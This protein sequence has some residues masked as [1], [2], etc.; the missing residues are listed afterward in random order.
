M[1]EVTKKI[2]VSLR[3]ALHWLESGSPVYWAV[4]VTL[5]F[6][7]ILFPLY[8]PLGFIHYNPLVNW[9]DL[10]SNFWFAVAFI[11]LT[12]SPLG[13]LFFL[14]GLYAIGGIKFLWLG[15]NLVGG[16][17][18]D[19]SELLQVTPT[20]YI[21]LAVV[22]I[23]VMVSFLFFIEQKGLRAKRSYGLFMVC[24]SLLVVA[25]VFPIQ[26]FS[27]ITGK[28]IKNFSR[29]ADFLWGG[30]LYAVGYDLIEKRRTQVQLASY[31]G[32]LKSRVDF[33]DIKSK[34]NI[35]IIL[36]ESY[37]SPYRLGLETAKLNEVPYRALGRV[38]YALAPVFGGNSAGSEYEILCGNVEHYSFGGLTFNAFGR[39]DGSP[40]L[41]N[42]LKPADY[43]SFATIG[44]KKLFFNADRAYYS[45]GF[46]QTFS[47]EDHP[48]Q[49]LDGF[50]ISDR[51]MFATN[52]VNLV[53]RMR[54]TGKPVLNY[55]ATIAGHG[56]YYLN[57][58]LRPIKI[59]HGV[60]G[61]QQY[62]NRIWYT[63]QEL[64]EHLGQLKEIDPDS[65]VF[66]V[67][68][69][70][71]GEAVAAMSSKVSR[72]DILDKRLQDYVLLDNFKQVDAGH[73]AYN[74]VPAVI[75]NIL[76]GSGAVALAKDR[77]IATNMGYFDRE[78][79]A[80]I[81]CDGGG[82]PGSLCSV[83]ESDK[84]YHRELGLNIIKASLAH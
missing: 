74:E 48:K 10:L 42:L 47:Y 5:A 51:E 66:I 65:I 50:R 11:A 75:R 30:Q 7:G 6:A 17:F 56:P 31:S 52:R 46:S 22:A 19:L 13:A 39:L 9:T 57:D 45:M 32:I 81:K 4:L 8:F 3:R 2:D 24:V 53:Q 49:D 73:I 28:N 54:E 80:P 21:F 59:G 68:D 40:C 70:L 29:G 64:N 76:A 14:V 82:L 78:S 35:H 69:H 34:K 26:A 20:L 25:C 37:T 77:P 60:A 23:F 62:L 15:R 18:Y 36:L 38:T 43:T 12:G 71:V 61:V 79:L 84:A 16:D 63:S 33:H 1:N 41:P 55:L 58:A 83:V 27:L 44:T 72:N 67:G